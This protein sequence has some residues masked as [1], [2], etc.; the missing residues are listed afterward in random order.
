M[1]AIK[2]MPQQVSVQ[3]EALICQTNGQHNDTEAGCCL[4]AK[5]SNL[6]KPYD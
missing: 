1:M 5:D 2:Q 6:Q 3:M 4:Q